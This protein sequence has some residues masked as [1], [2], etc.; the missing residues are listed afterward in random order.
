MMLL[1]IEILYVVSYIY[2]YIIHIITL[3]VI[4]IRKYREI[5]YSKLIA[6]EWELP[7]K[8]TSIMISCITNF[9]KLII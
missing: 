2:I 4:I 5:I 9:L 1:Y 6:A 3:K 8:F 7:R